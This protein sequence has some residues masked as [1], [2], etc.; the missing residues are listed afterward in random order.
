VTDS[1]TMSVQFFFQRRLKEHGVSI[2]FHTLTP[3]PGRWEQIR[4]AIIGSHLTEAD[5]GAKGEARE[6]YADAF[7]RASGLP[8][9]VEAAA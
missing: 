1:K 8:L 3:I 2:H 4:A 5:F 6:S 9:R 7:M